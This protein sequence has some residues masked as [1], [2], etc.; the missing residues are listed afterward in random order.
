MD[1]LD[2]C[3]PVLPCN[4]LS[5]TQLSAYDYKLPTGLIAQFP[6]EKRDN[7]RMMVIHRHAGLIE[8]RRFNQLGNYLRPND[9]LVL[10][11]TRVLANRLIGHRQGF[12]GQVEVFLLHPDADDPT[13]WTALL[14]PTRKL[15]PGTRIVFDATDAWVE[16]LNLPGGTHAQVKCHL[17]A[18]LASVHALMAL[19]GQMPIPPYLGR[20]ATEAD[21]I[22]YQTVYAKQPGSHA[23]PTAGLHFT[24]A[25]LAD[26][27]QEG[28]QQAEV[29]L[30]VST[31]TF[32]TVNTED[33]TQH[34]MDAEQ[35]DIP[36]SSIQTIDATRQLGGRVVAVGTTSVKTLETA[37]HNQGGQLLEAESGWSSLY[38]TPGFTF[39]SVDAMITNFHLPKSTLLMLVSAFMGHELM[40]HAY[41][42]A[43]E[44]QYR[45]YSYGDCMLIL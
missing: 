17:G 39:Q 37:S 5:T 30:N 33:I 31:G 11:N 8:H 16:V 6:E 43:V 41:R 4:P 32:R 27:K 42:V 25:M 20:S 15:E 19:I 34:A 12:T 14:R 26:L 13:V 28:I 36:H 24:Q 7:A 2:A 3:M 10:N 22:R 45:F 44:N 18:N 23:A 1:L 21:K 38:I 40:H 29:T 9:C 35:Y